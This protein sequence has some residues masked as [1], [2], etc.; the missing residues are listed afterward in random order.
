MK[1]AT[2]VAAVCLFM[3][4]VLWPVRGFDASAQPSDEILAYEVGAGRTVTVSVPGGVNRVIVSTWLLVGLGSA[5]ELFPYGVQLDVVDFGGAS[6]LSRTF[7]TR[8]RLSDVMADTDVPAAR[9][10]DAAAWVC[11]P[12]T[13]ELSLDELRGGAGQLTIGTFPNGPASPTVLLRL[14][15]QVERGELERKVLERT[16]SPQQMQHIMARRS[17]LG[18]FDIPEERRADALMYWE[19]RLTALGQEGRDYTTRRLLLGDALPRFQREPWTEVAEPF[20]PGRR[21]ALTVDG[22]GSLRVHAEPMTELLVV[23]GSD[24]RGS[25]HAVGQEGFIDLEFA[26]HG[27]RG[28]ELHPIRDAAIA[29]STDSLEPW[30]TSLEPSERAGRFE[31]RPDTRRQTYYRLDQQRPVDVGLVGDQGVLGLRVRVALD[32]GDGRAARVDAVFEDMEGGTISKARLAVDREPSILE[33]L[34]GDATIADVSESE[35]VL[36]HPPHGAVRV[37]LFGTPQTLVEAFVPE[38]GV[39]APV[40]LSPYDRQPPEGLAWRNAPWDVSARASIHPDNRKQLEFDGRSVAVIVQVHLEP[41]EGR[42]EPIV[43]RVLRPAGTPSHRY[44]MSAFQYRVTEK[45]PDD[46]WLLVETGRTSPKF[47]VDSSG[48]LR[49]MYL[50]TS[51]AL[52][53]RFRLVV[54]GTPTRGEMVAVTSGSGS[55]QLAPGPHSLG[56]DGLPKGSLLALEAQP[57]QTATLAKRQ[58]VYG[59]R[60][61]RTINIPFVRNAGERLSVVLFAVCA[62]ETELEFRFR[63]DG[64]APKT[65]RQFFRR[66]SDPEGVVGLRTGDYGRGV[67]WEPGRRRLS[68][69]ADAVGRAILPFGDDLVPGEHRLDL[70]LTGG[71]CGGDRVWVR[72]VLVGRRDEEK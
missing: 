7:E 56:F 17:S 36:L 5:D 23:D 40:H 52:G 22:P 71:G 3:L 50:T 28:I 10:A 6:V 46:G 33:W 8:S 41:I 1:R 39:I 24:R 43:P 60:R 35:T 16:L 48:E 63:L 32:G 14:T 69:T 31:L 38:P 30:V 15:Y 51:E 19:R 54:D 53:E 27:L 2:W 25:R 20:G 72:A 12:R 64:G 34:R 55:L 26:D 9:L 61:N 4:A 13:F 45:A 65:H 47:L 29:L 21:L 18:F 59:L 57:M 67:I 66:S 62:D 68:A 11:E 42:G 49:W 44:L 70:E 58:R 37:R